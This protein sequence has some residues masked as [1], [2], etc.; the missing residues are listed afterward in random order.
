[1]EELE[2]QQEDSKLK[3]EQADEDLG[4]KI[5]KRKKGE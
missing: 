4:P 1:M 3:S 2:K 5:K